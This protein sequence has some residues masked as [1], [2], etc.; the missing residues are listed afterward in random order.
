MNGYQGALALMAAFGAIGGITGLVALLNSR[1][2]RRKADGDAANAISQAAATLVTPLH[3]EVTRLSGRL[4]LLERYIERQREILT[5]HATWDAE[6]MI[7]L[8]DA[9]IEIGPPPSLFPLT[10]EYPYGPVSDL[11]E[12]HP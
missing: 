2:L 4:I 12:L 8:R 6:A 9:G 5:I 1:S 11:S 7:R 10:Q 3:D